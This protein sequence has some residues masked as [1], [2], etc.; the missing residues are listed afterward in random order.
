MAY[1]KAK[2]EWK[3]KKWKEAEERILREQ[4]VPKEI[5]EALR[6]ADWE[7]FKEERR[8]RERQILCPSFIDGNGKVTVDIPPRDVEE[9]LSELEHDALRHALSAADQI[10]LQIAF[11]TAYGFSA[12]EIA[13]KLRLTEKA[14]Y[15][16]MD[17]LREKA[18]AY[19]DCGQEPSNTI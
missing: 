17:R 14:V 6:N 4:N 5:I 10:T 12:R 13:E 16:R 2:E 15:R 3:W 11:M 18:R 1:N 7:C 8:Y 19:L 9:F